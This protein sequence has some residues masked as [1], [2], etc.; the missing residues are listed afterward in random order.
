MASP[1][2]AVNFVIAHFLA[3]AGDEV[4]KRRGDEQPVIREIDDGCA[5]GLVAGESAA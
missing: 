2:G 3:E 5:C 4:G 1:F